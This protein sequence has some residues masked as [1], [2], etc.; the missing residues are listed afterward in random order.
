MYQ[1]LQPHV[2]S[3]I[4]TRAPNQLGAMMT[5][6]STNPMY[7]LQIRR[8]AGVLCLEVWFVFWS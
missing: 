4:R 1:R 2:L 6:E 5:T 7:H 8:E 3:G